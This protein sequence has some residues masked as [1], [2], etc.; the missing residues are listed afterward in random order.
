M[1]LARQKIPESSFIDFVKEYIPKIHGKYSGPTGIFY[2][3]AVS[4]VRVQDCLA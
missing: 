3:H 1:L 4:N 2:Q